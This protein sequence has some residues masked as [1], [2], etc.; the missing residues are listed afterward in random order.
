MNMI[1]SGI[2]EYEGKKRAFVR[3][4][5]EKIT[6]KQPFPIARYLNQRVLTKR[7]FHSWKIICVPIWQCLKEKLPKAIRSEL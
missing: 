5:E 3:F 2:S 1:V 7:K 4:E 6:P